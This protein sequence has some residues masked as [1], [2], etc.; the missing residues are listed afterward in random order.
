MDARSTS[1]SVRDA[2]ARSRRR[3]SWLLLAVMMVAGLGGGAAVFSLRRIDQEIQVRLSQQLAG[4][5]EDFQIVIANARR[6]GGRG[7][8]IRGLT[9]A[10]PEGDPLAAIDELIVECNVEISQLLTRSIVPSIER[11][12]VRHLEFHCR[13]DQSKE[14]FEKLR[15]LPSRDSGSFPPI[16]IVDASVRLYGTDQPLL[17]QDLNLDLIP[18]EDAPDLMLQGSMSADFASQIQLTGKIRHDATRWDLDGRVADFE[19]S[20]RLTER[21]PT[22]IRQMI[23]PLAGLQA[24]GTLEFKIGSPR[25]PG[26]DIRFSVSG[27][28]VDGQ[29]QDPRW[30]TP[31]TALRAEFSGDNG[32]FELHQLSVRNGATTIF[33]AGN[34]QGWGAEAPRSGRLRL[35]DLTVDRELLEALPERFKSLVPK[36][37][38]EGMV[39][40]DLHAQMQGEELHA[41]AVVE[42]IDASFSYHKFPYRLTACR[43]IVR[44]EDGVIQARRLRALANGQPLT[45]SFEFANPGVMSTGWCTV[46]ADGPVPLDENLIMALEPK[47]RAIVLSLNA[48]GGIWLKQ[49]RVSRKAASEKYLRT[50][51]LVIQEGAIEYSKFPYPITN[52]SGVLELN[53][54]DWTISELQGRH[55]SAYLAGQGRWVAHDNRPGGRL[56]LDLS[57]ND[58]PLDEELQSALRPQEQEVWS[59]LRLTGS[60]DQLDVGIRFDSDQPRVSIDVRAQKWPADRNLEGRSIRIRPAWFPF[61]LNDLR[62]AVHYRDGKLVL[63]EVRARHN[64]TEILARGECQF[65]PRGQWLVDFKQ[66]DAD[67]V[68]LNSDLVTALPEKLATGITR[69]AFDGTVNLHGALRMTGV[70]GVVPESNWDVVMHAYDANLDCG[71]QLN[72]VHGSVRLTGHHDKDGVQCS[73]E[74][75]VDSL[76]YQDAQITSLKGPLWIDDD[77]V[78]LGTWAERGRKQEPRELSG[79]V[80]GGKLLVDSEI[81][82]R[83]EVNFGI[84][85]SL[86]NSDLARFSKERLSGEHDL[87]GRVYAILQL[88][89]SNKGLYA[90]QG[91]GQVRLRNADVYELPVMVRLLKL[92]TIKPP[93]T[94]A[95]TTADIDFRVRGESIYFDT[96]DFKGDAISLHGRNSWMNLD[97]ELNLR[98]YTRVGRS[99]IQLPL[100][101]SLLDEASRNILEIEVGGTLE[102]PNVRA[103]GFPEIDETLQQLFPEA[104][105]ARQSDGN[106]LTRPFRT[107]RRR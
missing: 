107:M 15:S 61:A 23:A 83:D 68:V 47:S 40:I 27:N 96:I 75:D 91:S 4:H 12:V 2:P 17:I 37:S 34:Q 73:G 104:A 14:I 103:K 74:L 77:R 85:M 101:T 80:F 16:Q 66:L 53:D 42:C 9:I 58:V 6:V 95:F 25:E 33:V 82:L 48:Q 89:G 35:R 26:G 3:G 98:F 84:K 88:S 51:V 22:D 81:W 44:Y 29:L 7:I 106:F 64:E 90:L 69:M 94:T 56:S 100:I 93:D 105:R 102:E 50:A 59:K 41:S 86:A 1:Q 28:V 8:E 13:P 71:V 55:G 21:L 19:F 32:H 54:R 62:G 49:L 60:V 70:A 10:S 24:N 11:V 45:I 31:F 63:Q 99:Q 38:P 78:L 30:S 57:A 67:R 39:N 43:G 5:L 97:R 46:H 18:A 79:S 92:L 87:S 76:I 52:V 20:P 65:G 36:F 72:H